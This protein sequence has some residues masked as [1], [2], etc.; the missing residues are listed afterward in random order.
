MKHIT[1]NNSKLSYRENTWDTELFKKHTFEILEYN[2]DLEN[3]EVLLDKMEVPS[4]DAVIMYRCDANDLKTKKVLMEQDFQVMETSLDI[5]LSLTASYKLPAIYTKRSL[6]LE[7]PSAEQQL[8]IKTFI[9][10]TFNYSRFHEDPLFSREC[11]NKRMEKRI[12]V[13]LEQNDFKCLI[14]QTPSGEIVSFIYYREIENEIYFELGG[15]KEGKGHYTP[16]FWA[17]LIQHFKSLEIKKIRTR[18][19][20][21]NI[22]VANIYWSFGF[23]IS[24]AVIDCHKHI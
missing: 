20:A 7:V 15:S 6:T 18:I 22:G 8:E 21:A 12:D 10:S 19:S 5:F 14:H 16:F 24:S 3:F 1:L 9:G 13:F 2:G 23:K 17:S 11:A 4:S